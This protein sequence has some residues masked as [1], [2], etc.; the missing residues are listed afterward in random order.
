MIKR[1]ILIGWLG[2]LGAVSVWANGIAVDLDAAHIELGK[3][4]RLTLTFDPKAAQGMPDFS[5]LQVDFTILATE[6]S[7]SYT[8]MNGQAHSVAQWGLILQPKHAGLITIP[9]LHIG[10][11]SSIP[12]QLNVSPG[13]SPA[14]PSPPPSP[15]KPVSQMDADSHH[16]EID[17]NKAMSLNVTVD[18]KNPYLHQEVLYKVRLVTRNP[19]VDVRYQP[20]QVENAILFPLGA[21]QEYQTDRD[22]VAYHVAEQ[23]YA[24]FPQKSGRVQI[25]APTLQALSYDVIPKPVSLHGNT[26]ALQVQPLPKHTIRRQW[27][28]SK[29]VRLHE[30]YDQTE[31][32]FAQ[33]ETLVRTITLQAQG[34]VAQL[35][36]EITLQDSPDIRVYPG[37]VERDNRIQQEE[38][39][40]RA[41]IKVTYVFAKSGKVV[42]PAIRVPWFNIKTK[43]MEIAE[44]PE[45]T[46]EITASQAVVKKNKR[47]RAKVM[48]VAISGKG[49]TPA[50]PAWIKPNMIM[51]GG[52]ILGLSGLILAIVRW[53]VRRSKVYRDLRAACKSNDV[54]RT[55]AAL[56]AWG[57]QYWPD[58]HIHHFTEILSLVQDNEALRTALQSFTEVLYHPHS[59]TVWKGAVLWRA[60]VRF[61]QQTVKKAKRSKAIPG[62]HSEHR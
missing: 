35:L 41:Q 52:L 30:T 60:I 22:G 34:L 51:V 32:K 16:D 53:Q 17:S 58:K 9:S 10:A 8:M 39:W 25:T 40:G 31:A 11:L 59:Q 20:P 48:P 18:Q 3:Q 4:V 55:K 43:T 1:M 6:Q 14:L 27:L 45:K 49:V 5:A 26:V 24:I 23:L 13:A 42:L 33:G 46:Y 61:K 19:L 7:M 21:G 50:L 44:L 38:L 54:T 36:P 15:S 47:F 37:Q 57:N 28:P 12:V 2:I 29:L 62:I 56:V